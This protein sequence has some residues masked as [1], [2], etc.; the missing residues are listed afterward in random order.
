MDLMSMAQLLGNLGEFVGAIA[1][2]ATLIYLALQ[3]RHNTAAQRTSSV[4]A[5]TQVFNQTHT[6]IVEHADV[7]EIM[8]RAREGPLASGADSTR[9]FSVVMPMVNGYFAAWRAHKNGHLPSDA[10]EALRRDSKVLLWPG[11]MPLL[12]EALAG[13]EQAFIDDFFPG[14]DPRKP[15][16]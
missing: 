7:A 13:R 1:V 6:S 5:M 16:D 15:D 14:G 11:L 3:I 4:W 2:V 10:Y 9:A 12:E 8:T